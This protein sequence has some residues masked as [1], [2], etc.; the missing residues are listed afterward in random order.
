[1]QQ[2]KLIIYSNFYWI[3]SCCLNFKYVKYTFLYVYIIHHAYMYSFLYTCKCTE[4]YSMILMLIKSSLHE[5]SG[6]YKEF[7]TVFISFTWEWKNFLM[8]RCMKHDVYTF[9][10]YFVV[11]SWSH[12]S[13]YMGHLLLGLSSSSLIYGKELNPSSQEDAC[14]SGRCT[15]TN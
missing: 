4:L 7:I 10:F 8:L 13:H 5:N 3:L 6:H 15:S 2:C 1:M 9:L 11:L 14:F 12:S